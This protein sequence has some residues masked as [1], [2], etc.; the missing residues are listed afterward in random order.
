VLG[1]VERIVEG[2]GSSVH[3]LTPELAQLC[4]ATRRVPHANTIALK[5][6]PLDCSISHRELRLFVAVCT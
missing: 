6:G 2:V 4:G 1:C 3:D 5:I